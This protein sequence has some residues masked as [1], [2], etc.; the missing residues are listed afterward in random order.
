MFF[1]SGNDAASFLVLEGF[2][3]RSNKVMIQNKR[4]IPLIS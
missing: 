2:P 4:M 1:N 3:K